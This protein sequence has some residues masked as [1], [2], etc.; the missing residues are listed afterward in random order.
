MGSDS[1]KLGFV[2]R[3][4][5]SSGS[6]TTLLLLHGTGGNEEDL[7]PLGKRLLPGAAILSPRGKVLENGMPR[8]FRRLAEGVFDT[9]DLV[10]RTG[11]LAEFLGKASKAYGFDPAKVVAV[12]YSNGANIAASLL[13]L[14]PNV[15]AGAVLLR[16]MVPFRLQGLPD[17]SKTKIL[18]ESG[19][20]DALIPR[21]L[22]EELSG[23]LG[24]AG[25]Q[26]SLRWQEGGGH[27]LTQSDI[28]AAA[29]WLS[30]SFA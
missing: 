20:D 30:E 3:F 27:T 18:I 26:V 16:P 23:I 2:H 24:K 1:Q 29:R 22:P 17:L 14:H 8:F 7:I 21:E 6:P 13:L 15:L 11:E 10:N 12:G 4:V 9:N 28:E 5:P 19:T 25:A